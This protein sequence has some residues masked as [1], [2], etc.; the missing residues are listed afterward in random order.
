[1]MYIDEARTKM[2]FAPMFFQMDLIGYNAGKIP[3]VNN[4][5]SWGELFNPK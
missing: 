1:M 5:L 4:E 3:A 2:S